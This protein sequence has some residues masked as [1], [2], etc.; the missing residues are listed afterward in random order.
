ME[1]QQALGW[2]L[3]TLAQPGLTPARS[4]T[5]DPFNRNPSRRA[6]SLPVSLW[7]CRGITP[8]AGWLGTAAVYSVLALEAS[9]LKSGCRQGLAPSGGLRGESFDSGLHLSDVCLHGPITSSFCLLLSF[10]SL[11]KDACDG[12]CSPSR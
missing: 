10:A 7:G 5:S 6:G 2:A 11:H 12:V 9:S 8:Q 3:W 1:V 4:R